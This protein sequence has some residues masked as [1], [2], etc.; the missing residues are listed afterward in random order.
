M[1]PGM[2]EGRPL[3]E[4]AQRAAAREAE[5][6]KRQAYYV[7]LIAGWLGE[8]PREECQQMIA[9]LHPADLFSLSNTLLDLTTE[10]D[11][12]RRVQTE[13]YGGFVQPHH[14]RFADALPAG[15]VKIER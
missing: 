6:E 5:G 11:E 7:R 12:S 3:E 14:V 15:D 1:A 9:A 2:G 8:L 13:A 10:M 4:L